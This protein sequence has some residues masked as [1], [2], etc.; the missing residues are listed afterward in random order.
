MKR[1]IITLAALAAL[2]TGAASAAAA[3]RPTIEHDKKTTRTG[4]LAGGVL[5]ALVG[6]PPGAIAG[7][8]LGGYATDRELAAGRA[9]A[10]AARNDQLEHERLALL[11][12]GSSMTVRAREL[13][14]QLQHERARAD[15]AAETIMLADGL[16]FAVGF[17]TNSAAPPVESREGLEALA[18]LV[19]AVPSLQI[20]LDGYADSRGGEKLNRDLSL[21]RA[22]AVRDQLI[23]A[24]VAPDRI[25]V[26]AHG[27]TAA[28]APGQAEDQD[29][30]ALQRRVNIRIESD[31][32]R[33]AS[34]R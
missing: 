6:G 33:V 31:G 11:A 30:W 17:R 13:S 18:V 28:F 9:D 26:T 4:L 5:G 19:G 7:M 20:H 14:R 23:A 25:H 27:A 15:S 1:R 32:G 16:E 34:K 22:E 10:L 29:E 12:E 3:D 24:G 8:V 21:A 2:A